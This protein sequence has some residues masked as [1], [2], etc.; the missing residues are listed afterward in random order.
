MKCVRLRQT[1]VRFWGIRGPWYWVELVRL[2]A[3]SGFRFGSE[4]DLR[5]GLW[6]DISFVMVVEMRCRSVVF[7]VLV[8]RRLNLG[9]K[10]VRQINDRAWRG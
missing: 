6:M 5:S 9:T 1:L 7:V 3:K 10:C 2:R 4:L 8:V